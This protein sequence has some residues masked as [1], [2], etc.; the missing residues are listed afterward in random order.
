MTIAI[1]R[2]KITHNQKQETM[3]M[4]QATVIVK[5]KRD[6]KLITLPCVTWYA[7]KLFFK[8]FEI[9]DIINPKVV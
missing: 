1:K 3:K 7:G 2:S 8:G 9:V 4:I 6:G 5:D